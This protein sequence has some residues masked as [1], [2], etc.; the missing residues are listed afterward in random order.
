MILV[1]VTHSP[2]TEDTN[3]P[4]SYESEGFCNWVHEVFLEGYKCDVAVPSLHEAIK[5]VTDL[6]YGVTST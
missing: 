3:L 2:H 4:W 5:I 6:G 1:T